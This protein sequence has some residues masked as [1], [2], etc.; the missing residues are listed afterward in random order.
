MRWDGRRWHVV[1]PGIRQG[2]K[3]QVTGAGLSGQVVVLGQQ[4]LDDGAELQV[5]EVQR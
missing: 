1:E 2:G 4:L 5:V 3:V